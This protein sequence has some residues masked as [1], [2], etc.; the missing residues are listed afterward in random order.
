MI[1][2]SVSFTGAKGEERNCQQSLIFVRIKK[3]KR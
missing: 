1:N 3:K 2:D